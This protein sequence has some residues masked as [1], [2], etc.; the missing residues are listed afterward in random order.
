MSN[1][2]ATQ[3]RLSRRTIERDLDRGTKFLGTVSKDARVY[4]TLVDEAGYDEAAHEEGWDLHM[5][6]LG[7]RRGVPAP[8][9]VTGGAAQSRAVTVLDQWDGPNFTRSRFALRYSYPEQ[10]EYIFDGLSAGR[11]VEAVGAVKTFLDRVDALRDGSDPSREA[12]R[13]ADREA[14]ELL[15]TR[16][17][18]HEE[19][20]AELREAIRV[21]T[22]EVPAPTP[23]PTIDPIDDPEFQALARRYHAWL[24]DWRGQAREV[25]QRRDYLSRLGLLE[26]RVTEAST[27]TTPLLDTVQRQ[28]TLKFGSLSASIEGRLEMAAPEEL[29]DLAERLIT[30][31]TLDEALGG[32]GA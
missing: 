26:T 25:V 3:Q 8:R 20:V 14:A 23:T 19:R 21:A 4:A 9:A 31:Q 7:Y 32:I 30:A 24:S 13:Q 17:I 1:F 10:L 22:S 15:A 6:V 11:N 16:R 5:S 12:T 29:E 27:E 2:D 18:V 28:L